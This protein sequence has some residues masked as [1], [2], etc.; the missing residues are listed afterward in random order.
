MLLNDLASS[1]NSSERSTVLSPAPLAIF[2]A[3]MFKRKIGF[4]THREVRIRI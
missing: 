1:P 3:A 2:F 4:V